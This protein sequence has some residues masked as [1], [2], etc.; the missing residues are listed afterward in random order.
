MQKELQEQ[1]L[2]T[3][4]WI[5]APIQCGN[6]WYALLWNLNLKINEYLEKRNIKNFRVIEI[7]EKFGS[8]RI[9]SK[10]I[11]KEIQSLIDLAEEQSNFICEFCGDNGFQYNI[12]G[13][14]TTIC[15]SCLHEIIK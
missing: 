7:K 2:S 14:V 13:W 11:Y 9:H 3:F 5:D 4:K 6:G 8:L 12:R 1:F 15:N 10:P